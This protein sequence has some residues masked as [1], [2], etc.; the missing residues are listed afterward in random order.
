MKSLCIAA[1]LIL[2]ITVSSLSR[3]VPTPT[4][5]SEDLY[6]AEMQAAIN[7]LPADLKTRLN[8]ENAKLIQYSATHTGPETLE[9]AE[10]LI[11]EMTDDAFDDGSGVGGLFPPATFGGEINY[12]STEEERRRC[13][14][15]QKEACRNDYN[16]DL[17]Q[18]AGVGT[19]VF[20][21]C[22]TFTAGSGA[23]VCGVGG[24]AVHLLGVAA[25]RQRRQA[26]ELRAP[27]LCG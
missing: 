21:G 13:I 25:A 1:T 16:A 10:T 19:G 5:T 7:T 23:L 24:F 11:Y 27:Y 4:V 17:F 12:F 2:C 18:S 14:R 3:T 6:S 15:D 26:C 9:Y 22:T 20:L 8:S